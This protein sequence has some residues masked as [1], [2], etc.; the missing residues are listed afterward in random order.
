[1]TNNQ[2]LKFLKN[3]VLNQQNSI[4][5]FNSSLNSN[6]VKFLNLILN[7]K[8]KIIFTGLGKSGHITKKVSSTFSSLGLPSLYIHPTEALH[9]DMGVIQSNDLLVCLSNS[10][11]TPEIISLINSLKK[12]N[13]ETTIVGISSNNNS[14]L[15]KN[16]KLFIELKINNEASFIES[17]PTTSTTISL[18]FFDGIANL[19]SHING[20]TEKNFALIHPLGVIGMKLNFKVSDIMKVESENSYISLDESL[21]SGISELTKKGLGVVSIV[22]NGVLKGILTD[23]DL[24]RLL[25]RKEIG[26]L[27]F[28]PI[29]EFM[30]I[31]PITIKPNQRLSDAVELMEN[32]PRQI[33]VLP[34]VDNNNKLLGTLRLHDIIKLGIL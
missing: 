27:L 8:G 31:N 2:K 29:K 7:C 34:V 3:F 9:G 23:G 13:N 11:N 12:F 26:K 6:H 28:K 5:I 10:G 4:E 15:S 30:T 20:F 24:K 19:A 32:R 14:F 17:V 22:D 18:I 21:K 25:D 33:S 1:M 16:T